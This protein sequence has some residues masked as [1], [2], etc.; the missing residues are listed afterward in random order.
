M[1]I[2]LWIKR[3]ILHVLPI[4]LFFLFFFTLIN[5]METYL[6]E[7]S[8]IRAFRFLEVVLAAALI[9]KIVLVLDHL[10]FIDRFRKHPLAYGIIWKTFMYWVVLLLVRLLIRFAPFFW[11]STHHLEWDIIEFFQRVRWNV[12]FSIQGY[13]LMLLFIFVTFQELAYKIGIKKMRALFFGK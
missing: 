4:F 7:G 3:E 9:A 2:F 12:F 5:W 13:Y 1:K 10:P 6:F 11:S 8:G